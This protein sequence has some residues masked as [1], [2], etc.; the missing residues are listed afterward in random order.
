MN[1]MTHDERLQS[2]WVLWFHG[3]RNN[4]WSNDSYAILDVASTIGDVRRVRG[5]FEMHPSFRT[6]RTNSMLFWMRERRVDDDKAPDGTRCRFVYPTWEDQCNKAGGTLCTS[7]DASHMHCLFWH[8][9]ARVSG[10]TLLKDPARG[11]ARI[12]G[13]NIVPKEG[14]TALVKVWYASLPSSSLPLPIDGDS[15][16]S[17][18]DWADQEIREWRVEAAEQVATLKKYFVP[19]T[20][21]KH[22]DT[23]ITSQRMRKEYHKER[24]L[25]ITERR[26]RRNRRVRRRQQNETRNGRNRR[27][28]RADSGGNNNNNRS[29]EGGWGVVR[30]RRRRPFDA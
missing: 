17:P 9:V 22:K 6:H 5:L 18:S 16:V 25:Q 10:E 23:K 27:W 29:D 1:N 8:M 4:N 2:R 19:H 14:G 30:R 7:G 3:T 26:G 12:N 28:Q 20:K 13:V 21:V 11:V 24:Q 15:S